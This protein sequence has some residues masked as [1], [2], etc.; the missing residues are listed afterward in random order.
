MLSVALAYRI[1]ESTAHMIVKE[2]CSV[3][4]NVLMPIYLK[5]PTEVEWKEIWS[6]FFKL[7]EFAKLC[8]SNRRQAHNNLGTSKLWIYVL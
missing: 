7:V 3:I 5:P 2:T 1:G 6:D 4:A 8:W